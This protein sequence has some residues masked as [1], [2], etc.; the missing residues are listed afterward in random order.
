LTHA[1]CFSLR[2]LERKRQMLQ[3]YLALVTKVPIFELCF[4]TGIESLPKVLDCIEQV[5]AATLSLEAK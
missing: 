1:Y 4:Q 5:A 2:H 3:S